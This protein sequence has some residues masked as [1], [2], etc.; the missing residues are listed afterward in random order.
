MVFISFFFCELM[1][2]GVLGSVRG[3]VVAVN[4]GVRGFFVVDSLRS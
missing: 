3:Y 4:R 2:R 1:V